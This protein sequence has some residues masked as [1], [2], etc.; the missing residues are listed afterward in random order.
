M[1][2]ERTIGYKY[3]HTREVSA[4]LRIREAYPQW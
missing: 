2:R 4:M 3:S 1:M